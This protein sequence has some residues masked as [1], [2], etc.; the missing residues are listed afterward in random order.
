MQKFLIPVVATLTFCL[1]ASSS[2]AQTAKDLVGTWSFV[3]IDTTSADGTKGQPFG[4]TP[5]GNVIFSDNGQF[6]WLVTR[7][8]RAKF[9]AGRRD[10]GTADE[11]K[12]T[13]Q[14]SLGY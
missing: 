14:G 6:V 11:N 13:V 2:T 10:Q 12:E 7:P 5:K 3:T 4:P 9:A 1:G 8:G